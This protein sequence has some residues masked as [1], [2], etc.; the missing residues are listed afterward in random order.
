MG[1]KEYFAPRNKDGRKLFVA[2]SKM[3]KEELREQGFT[4]IDEYAAEEPKNIAVVLGM[5]PDLTYNQLQVGFWLMQQG[6][7]L[8]LLN[9]DLLCLIQ[10]DF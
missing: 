6:A 8:I 7:E 2:G 10:K 1:L 3:I 5:T 9:G 4:V